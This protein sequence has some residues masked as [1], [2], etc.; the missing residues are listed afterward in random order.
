V[1]LPSG[2]PH[3]IR[4]APLTIGRN[5]D[6]DI[7]LDAEDVSRNHAYLLRTPQGF[8]LVDSSLHGTYVNGERVQ[9]QRLLGDGDE[10]QI[11]GHS[12][13]FELYSLDSGQDSGSSSHVPETSQH[14]RMVPPPAGAT[15]KVGLA[16][17]LARQS[18]WKQRLRIWVQRYG[19]S[20]LV[21]IAM[22]FAGSGL[23]GT[24]T[25]SAVAAA[26]GGAIGEMVGFYGSLVA[27]EL[28]TEAYFAGARRAPF[29]LR[30][31]IRTWRGLLL[32]FGPSELLDTGFIRPLAM[33]V[34]TRVLGWGAGLV[35]GKLLADVLFY[36]PVIW[37]YERRR[38]AGAP[39]H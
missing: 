17:A 23:L 31:M 2:Q 16:L 9:A 28:V 15:G 27:R 20:E 19:P 12:F 26:Y 38:R 7:A 6:S 35:A 33:G 18:S 32:E 37:I 14:R 21:G 29:G 30:E 1:P 4:G 11:G 3:L 13:R 5:P 39:G 24:A 25:G 34:G 22:A 36:L 10:I 8:L